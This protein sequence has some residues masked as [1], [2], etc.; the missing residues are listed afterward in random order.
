MTLQTEQQYADLECEKI[1]SALKGSLLNYQLKQ[2]PFSINLKIRKTF[3]SDKTADF[4]ETPTSISALDILSNSLPK[5]SSPCTPRLIN[6][7]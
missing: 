3:L 7:Q 1:I 2:S 4:S 6:S 5:Q